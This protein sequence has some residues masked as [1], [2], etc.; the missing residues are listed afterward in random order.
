VWS[1]QRS[2]D[3]LAGFK[4]PTSK[5][6]GGS[7]GKG[8]VKKGKE[9]KNKGGK[10]GEGTMPALAASLFEIPRENRSRVPVN[11]ASSY[12]AV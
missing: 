10:R 3:S 7:G 11:I 6:R 12:R 9:W 4:G 5:R 8:R 1:L 2:P